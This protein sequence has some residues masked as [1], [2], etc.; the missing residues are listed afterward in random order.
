MTTTVPDAARSDGR[1]AWSPVIH[2]IVRTIRTR[3]LFAQ[4]HHLLVAVSGG[5]DSVALLWILN[6]LR[7]S[8]R[9]RLT[10]VHFNYGLRGAESDGDQESVEAL[11][12]R[13]EIP[14][15]TEPLRVDKQVRGMSLQAA[16]REMRYHAMMTMAR[17]CGAD[18]VAVGHTAD[19]QAE[20]VLL[21]I[22]RGAGLT[23][24]SGMPATR[25]GVVVRPL[26]E[27][28]RKD[29]HAYLQAEGVPF[30][31]DSSND[32]PV[33]VRNRVRHEVIPALERVAPSA[34]ETVCRLADLCR[35][36]DRFLEEHVAALSEENI[37]RLPDGGSTIERSFLQRLPRPAQRR[38]I[39]NLCRGTDAQRRPPSL[40]AVE[41]LLRLAAKGTTVS[42][43]K[44]VPAGVRVEKD[45]LYF[46]PPEAPT[47]SRVR[48]GRVA[49]SVL[50]VPGAV[51][52]EATGQRIEARRLPRRSV[53]R[54]TGDLNG[55]AVDA[56]RI[57][58]PLVVRSWEPGDRFFPLGMNGRSKK[59][60]DF[61]TDLKVSGEDRM[62]IPVVAAPEGIVWIVGY[63]QDGRWVEN[64][65]TER[66]LI[67]T[68]QGSHATEGN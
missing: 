62:R 1:V 32:S 13:L 11:C 29:V 14:L 56:D 10:A 36:D 4:G 57:S 6:R 45:R 47:R 65:A 44:L 38:V 40:R 5:P 67:L 42:D 39:R 9:L 68:V 49:P 21:W 22:L 7:P 60:Q 2:R 50:T 35:E 23:G 19:D 28:R 12:R 52:W 64:E 48:P 24:L 59:L 43:P 51:R 17:T 54:S 55:I 61:F 66:S 63:R 18:R 53:R 37:A 26:Y 15:R 27:T 3:Q 58:A 16:A 46:L 34:V 25:D 41:R 8:W 33:Y 31:R 20:T 30:R